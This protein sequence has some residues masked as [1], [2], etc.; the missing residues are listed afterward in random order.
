MRLEQANID[1]VEENDLKNNFRRMF[2][3]LKEDSLKEMAKK[4]KRKKSTNPLKKSKRKQ[5]NM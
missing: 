2:E 4:Q 3:A 1:A 5:S